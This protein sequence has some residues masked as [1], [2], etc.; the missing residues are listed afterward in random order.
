MD[1]IT[2][3]AEFIC[4]LSEFRFVVMYVYYTNMNESEFTNFL[5]YLSNKYESSSVCDEN[6]IMVQA[7]NLLLQFGIKTGE[8]KNIQKKF[9]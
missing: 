5:S 3:K 4:F 9:F 6:Q 2:K 1:L 8:P 7:D